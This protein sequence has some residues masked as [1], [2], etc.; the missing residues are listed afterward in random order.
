MTHL[1]KNPDDDRRQAKNSPNRERATLFSGQ[2]GLTGRMINVIASR[3]EEPGDH[4]IRVKE[5]SRQGQSHTLPDRSK[6]RSRL[7]GSVSPGKSTS[8]SVHLHITHG[9]VEGCSKRKGCQPQPTSDIGVVEYFT[10]PLDPHAVGDV[11]IKFDLWKT[12]RSNSPQM[13][14]RIRT[15][16]LVL[17]VQRN[18]EPTGCCQDAR[19][20]TT[21]GECARPKL[22]RGLVS[23]RSRTVPRKATVRVAGASPLIGF[24]LKAATRLRPRECVGVYAPL[25]IRFTPTRHDNSHTTTSQPQPHGLAL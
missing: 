15:A 17:L 19:Q 9:A 11:H 3:Q 4:R 18:V 1:R 12:G 22:S 13:S 7:A 23:G 8:P 5:P 16:A 21:D 24:L 10:V 6:T 20:L 14:M 25:C 2:V